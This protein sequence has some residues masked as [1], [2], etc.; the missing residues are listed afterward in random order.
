MFVRGFASLQCGSFAAFAGPG[1]PRPGPREPSSPAG[2][3]MYK[4]LCAQILLAILSSIIF[5]WNICSKDR[6]P[7]NLAAA[8]ARAHARR[9]APPPSPAPPSAAAAPSRTSTPPAPA[10]PGQLWSVSWMRRSQ[11]PQTR[12][13]QSGQ[14]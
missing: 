9:A 4:A 8:R 1:P 6:S 13:A 11:S 3:T 14:R 7:C 10:Q 2:L 5:T 12:I